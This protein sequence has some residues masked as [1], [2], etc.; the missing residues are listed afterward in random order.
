MPTINKKKSKPVGLS[1][2]IGI[3]ACAYEADPA[4]MAATSLSLSLSLALALVWHW[5][6]LLRPGVFG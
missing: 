2:L 4:K 1:H 3:N 6:R 5:L